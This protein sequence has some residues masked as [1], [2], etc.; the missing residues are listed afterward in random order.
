MF[1]VCSGKVSCQVRET[2]VKTLS[3]GESFGDIAVYFDHLY[4]VHQEHASV[5]GDSGPL[6]AL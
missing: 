5:L 2:E 4:R 6:S 1:V 3:V